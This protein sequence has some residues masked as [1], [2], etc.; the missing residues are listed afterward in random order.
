MSVYLPPEADE[1][2][3]EARRFVLSEANR[4]GDIREEIDAIIGA[5][6]PNWTTTDSSAGTFT[7]DELALVLLALG[8]PREVD[9]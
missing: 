7:K 5:E 9:G 8:G 3:F 1:W 4:A 2:D 6:D